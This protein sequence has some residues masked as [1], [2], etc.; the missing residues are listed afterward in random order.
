MVIL[1]SQKKR[2]IYKVIERW[3]ERSHGEKVKFHEEGVTNEH[4]QA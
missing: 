3:L 1:T 2:D 4:K